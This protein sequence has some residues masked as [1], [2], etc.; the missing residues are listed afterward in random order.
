M[1]EQLSVERRI[2]L[3]H[4]TGDVGLRDQVVAEQLR[5]AHMVAK[6][7]D[8]R[9]VEYD[10]LFQVASFALVKAVERFSADRGLKF[11]TFVVPTMVGEVRNYFRDKMRLIRLPRGGSEALRRIAQAEEK[12]HMELQ[13]SPSARELAEKLGWRLEDVLE[14]LEMR[15][16]TGV[17]SL[18]RVAGDDDDSSVADHVGAADGALAGFEDREALNRA[19]TRLDAEEQ[20]LLRLRFFE[21]RSQRDVAARQGVS[22]MTVSRREKRALDKLRALLGDG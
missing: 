6:R 22:Q 21:N 9:G 18:D 5:L 1:D 12:L 19:L 14:T 8:G 17:E 13:R 15:L 11:S 16:A 2:A 10:D 20:E 4:E 3:Y 7:F